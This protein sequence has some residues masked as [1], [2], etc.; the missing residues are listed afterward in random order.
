MSEWL[1]NDYTTTDFEDFVEE[2]IKPATLW[3]FI[4]LCITI[5]LRIW[6]EY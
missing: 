3:T 5:A 4:L 6:L 2:K 1:Y